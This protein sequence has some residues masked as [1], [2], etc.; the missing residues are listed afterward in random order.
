[1]TETRGAAASTG[2]GAGDQDPSLTTLQRPR[3][4]WHRHLDSEERQRV[5]LELAIRRQEH[6]GFRFAMMTTLSVIV[7]VMGLSADSPLPW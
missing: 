2:T 7:A 3:V 5:M 4:W 1:M 6:W